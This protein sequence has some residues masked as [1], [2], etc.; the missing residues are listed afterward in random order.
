MKKVWKWANVIPMI[1]LVVA[2]FM[3]IGYASVNSVLFSVSGESIAKSMSNVFMT[4]ISATGL[5]FDENYNVF[6]GD[7]TNLSSKV[8]LSPT[9]KSSQFSLVIS[10]YN[11]SDYDYVFKGVN[12]DSE[13]VDDVYNN[14]DIIYTF[15]NQDSIIS[16]NGGV[17]DVTLTFKYGDIT[18]INSNVLDSIL[19]FDFKKRFGIVYNDVADTS[20]LPVYALEDD[21]IEIDMSSQTYYYF[22]IFMGEK[23]LVLNEDYTFNNRIIRI[24]N[25][26]GELSIS[27]FGAVTNGLITL[28]NPYINTASMY[29]D[30]EILSNDSVFDETSGGKCTYEDCYSANGGNFKY[31]SQG[32]L[33]LGGTNTIGVLNIDDSMNVLD[34][35]TAY[36]TFKGDANQLESSKRYA[37]AAIAISDDMSA[38]LL[39][40]GYYGGYMHVYVYSDTN[41][42]EYN[43][44]ATEVSFVSIDAKKYSNKIINL[45]V[46]GKR[47]G[48]SKLYINGSLIAS[49]DTNSE[50]INF[51]K[52]T[53]GDLRPGRGL[54]F[55][56]TIYD[57][58][59]YNRALTSSEITTNWNY[60]KKI[61]NI[62]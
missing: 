57:V 8:S 3:S 1:I 50:V 35:F 55:E 6:Y 59:L 53:I 48:K 25:V 15:D 51:R 18:Q 13:L 20:N 33:E 7:E 42:R 46:V 34:E 44:V 29:G 38:Y 4:N 52:A 49:F 19:N 61:W 32:G 11:N 40:I 60:A 36:M 41:R 5:D 30:F 27:T 23:K 31:D 24:P 39:W 2:F 9:D 16:K 21:T 14:L 43:K 12:Y 17:L 62:Q 54:K 47:G 26:D 10:F 58:A 28:S 22:A 37:T 45:Q 56:G